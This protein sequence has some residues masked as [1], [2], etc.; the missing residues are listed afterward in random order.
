MST[1]SRKNFWPIAGGVGVAVALILAYALNLS[2]S[3][4]WLFVNKTNGEA[5]A[6]DA[7]SN[8]TRIGNWK[9]QDEFI[10]HVIHVDPKTQ[11]VLFSPHDNHSVVLI[12]APNEVKN[13]V[14]AEGIQLQRISGN[15]FGASSE[16]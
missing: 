8:P 4:R 2:S 9:E 7:L 3:E 6:R 12:Y 14:L 15:W 1:F 11:T 10:D 16:Q 5:L 13:S